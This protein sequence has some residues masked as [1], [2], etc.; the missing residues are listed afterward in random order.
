MTARIGSYDNAL[1]T[2]AENWKM[3]DAVD[4]T[5]GNELKVV[6]LRE[7]AATG[8]AGGVTFGDD[9]QRAIKSVLENLNSDLKTSD[10][11]IDLGDFVETLSQS[12][13]AAAK[14]FED[15]EGY[16]DDEMAEYLS[17]RFE[18][19]DTVNGEKNGWFDAK[20][21]K[22][23]VEKYLDGDMSLTWQDWYLG[24]SLAYR[25]DDLDTNNNKKV[26]QA[27]VQAFIEENK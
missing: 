10:G 19:L 5:R 18:M 16:T 15:E 3:L 22:A 8:T 17:E 25:I 12:R 14:E 11:R 1:N 24:G 2:I 4:G 20:S 27:E 13:T 21:A 26:S 7:I 6:V 23:V 9:V